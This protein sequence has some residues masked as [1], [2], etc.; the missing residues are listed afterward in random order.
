RHRHDLLVRLDGLDEAQLM[1]GA[2][3]RKD[4]NGADSFLQRGSVHLLDLCAC[5]RC[6]SVADIEHFCDGRSCDLVIAGNHRDAN[7]AAV[8]FLHGLK[9]F[10]TRRVKQTDESK[11][12][13]STGKV[14]G[15][16]TAGLEVRVLQACE[17]QATVR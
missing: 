15:T 1:L 5:N 3:T 4:I 6:L 17:G 16:K 14:D 13:K 8:G 12:D 11:Q 9:G 10:F 2:C 7:S